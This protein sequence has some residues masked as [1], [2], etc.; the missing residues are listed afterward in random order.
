MR[1]EEKKEGEYSED[2]RGDV[3]FMNN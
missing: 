2:R 1:K 3:M